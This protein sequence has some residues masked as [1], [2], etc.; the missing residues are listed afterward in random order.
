MRSNAEGFLYPEIDSD[1]CNNCGLCEKTCP[2]LRDDLQNNVLE[3]FAAKNLNKEQLLRSASG[4][5]FAVLAEK[6][7]EQ[8]GIVFG[9]AYDENLAVKHIGIESLN[10]L[11]RLQSS[12]YVQS[13]TLDTYTHARN[14]LKQNRK[15]LYSGTPCQIAGLKAFC[16]KDCEN[17]T[18]MDLVCHGVPSPGLFAKYIE[19]LGKKIGGKIIYYNFRSKERG[20]WSYKLKA[21]AKTKTKTKYLKCHSDPYFRKFL[22]NETLRECCYSCKYTCG[23]RAG[24][25]TLADYWG[26]QQEHPV[27]FSRDGVSAILVN[28]QKGKS[29]FESIKNKAEI[30]QSTFENVAKHQGMLSR[31]AK[32]PAARDSAYSSID[33]S[34][35]RITLLMRWKVLIR[36]MKSLIPEKVKKY[37]RKFKRI[38]KL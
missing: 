4:G 10:E 26:I 35:F 3:T 8:S 28:T 37:L 7:L 25:I 11:H 32:R 17:L 22:L 30:I 34:F 31:P 2:I 29:L 9:C 16:G 33:E 15:V 1:L 27:F 18:T 5:I 13:D 23:K 38:I 20:G 14:F 21:K 12:K 19:W 24:D 36:D 6:I